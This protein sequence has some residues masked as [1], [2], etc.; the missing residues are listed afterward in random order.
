[1]NR[2]IRLQR[3]GVQTGRERRR[4]CICSAA[5]AGQTARLPAGTGK[6]RFRGARGRRRRRVFLRGWRSRAWVEV[7]GR[8]GEC[9]PALGASPACP[10]AA[11][12]TGTAVLPPAQLRKGT[13]PS[14]RKRL[15]KR[16]KQKHPGSSLSPPWLTSGGGGGKKLR[17]VIRFVVG[18]TPVVE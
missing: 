6:N 13:R 15:S 2:Q 8:G 7:G 10:G 3:D 11:S 12:G 14:G 18:D 5:P 16:T 17:K 9:G 4:L 1:M